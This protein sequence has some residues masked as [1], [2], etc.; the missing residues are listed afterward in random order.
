MDIRTKYL[1]TIGLAIITIG[2]AIVLLVAM[3]SVIITKGKQPKPIY[4]PGTQIEYH[5]KIEVEGGYERNE[6]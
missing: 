1:I 3:Y 4:P 5:E 6:V 2:L